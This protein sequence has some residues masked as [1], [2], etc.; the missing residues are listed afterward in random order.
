M[1]AA[2]VPEPLTREGF[3]PF[4]DVIMTDG[5][6]F[7]SIN[8]GSTIRFDDLATVDTASGGG[9]TLVNIFRA[10]PLP[11]PLDIAM[12]EKHPLGSQAFIPL[13]REPFLVVVAP[14]GA[15]IVP[16]DVRAFITD[17]GQG[18][19]YARG[20]W[21]HPVIALGGETDFLVIDRGGEGDNLAEWHFD[22][23]LP[24]LRLSVPVD[25]G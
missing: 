7:F 14:R 17:G 2:L 25:A 13:G 4:G 8:A 20:V 1:P 18:V 10:A 16:G 9:R 12:M 3:A 6:R 11:L 24:G 21:H 19:N 15:T 5:A 22:A 23:A